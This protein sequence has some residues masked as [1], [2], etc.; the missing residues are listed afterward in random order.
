MTGLLL[1]AVTTAANQDYLFQ[2]R[3]MQALSL[4]VHI[5][6]VCFGIAFPALVLFVEM[7]YLRTGDPLYRTLA[8][9]WSKVM[10]ALFA[11]GVMSLF[12]MA[13]VAV[14]VFAEKVLPRGDRITRPLAVALIALGIWVAVAPE[15][16]PWLTDPGSG[17]MGM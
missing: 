17:M 14:I 16:V 3:Q 7:L 1:A 6:L 8:R 15:S 13:L 12:W 4:A 11:V 2:A 9:R 5:P 10:L